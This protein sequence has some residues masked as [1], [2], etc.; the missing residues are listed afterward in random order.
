MIALASVQPSPTDLPASGDPARWR[1]L[2]QLRRYHELDPEPWLWAVERGLLEPRSDLLAVL[3]ERLDPVAQRRL[4]CWWRRQPRPDPALPGLVARDRDGATAAWLRAQLAPGPAALQGGLQAEMAAT[5]LP[6]LGHQRQRQAWPLLEAWLR[7]PIATPL[8]RAAL[9]GV[10]RGLPV[11]PRP[12]LVACLTSLAG[13][14]DPRLAATAVDLLARLPACRRWLVPLTRR[15]LAVTVAERLQRRL[16]ATP[17]QPLLLVVHGRSGGALPA[18]LQA[19]AT[20]L[21]QRRGTPVR[22]QA[23][24]ADAPPAA[25][26]LLKPGLALTLVPLLLLPGGHVRH[27]LPVIV[28]HWRRHTRVRRLPFLG[29]WP[30]W[31]RALQHELA[32][33]AAAGAGEQEPPLLLHHPVEGRLAGRFLSHLESAC[34]GRCLATPYSAEHLAALQLTLSAPALPLALA[35]NRF[36]DLLGDQVGAPLLQRP[37]LR[38]QL[39]DALEALP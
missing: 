9:E 14:L 11:W 32:A 20:E 8:R 1:W 29:A 38:R 24:T 10:A 16:A 6:L 36:T 27:D 25:A 37:G 4:L 31:Q 34:G 12:A 21:E 35:A 5:L 15:P 23:L 13:D 17:A 22:L 2:Q 19:L 28:R 30:S 18:E 3:A 39:L 33:M 26:A 7:A